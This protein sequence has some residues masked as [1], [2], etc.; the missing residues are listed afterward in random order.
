MERIGWTLA[1][2]IVEHI[3]VPWTV[4]DQTPELIISESSIKRV[5]LCVCVCVCVS[6]CMCVLVAQS[7]PTHCDPMDCSLPGSSIYGILQAR[8]LVCIAWPSPWESPWPRDRTQVSCISRQLLYSLSHW[9]NLSNKVL[10]YGTGNYIEYPVKNH[11]GKEYK[12]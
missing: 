3:L 10:L 1:I 4:N 8:I 9:G 6:V 5:C 2:A 11:N 12:K 7:F